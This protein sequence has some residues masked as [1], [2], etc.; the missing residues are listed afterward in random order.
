MDASRRELLD[1]LQ[2]G[3]VLLPA[4]LSAP[5]SLLGSLLFDPEGPLVA[6]KPIPHNP[7]VRTNKALVALVHGTDAATMLNAG[8]ELFG[9]LNRLDLGGKRVLLKPNVVNDRPPP[10]TTSVPVVEAVARAVKEAGAGEVFV[11]DSSGI[12]RFPT[13]ENLDA[14]GMRAAA[15]RAGAKV[16]ALEVHPWVRVEPPR[17]SS[18]RHYYLSR[19]VYEADVFINLPVIKTH[20]FADYSCSLKNL[21]GVTHPRYR[22]SVT[23]LSGE[24]HERIAELNLAVHP[25]LTIADGTMIMVAG[26]PTSGTA[27]RG[28]LLLL[29]GDRVA[30]DVV[31]LAILRSFKQWPKIEGGPVWG[32]RQVKRAIELGLGVGTPGEV[33]LVTATTSG[34]QEAFERLVEVIRQDVGLV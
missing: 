28:D 31:A 2:W 22:P 19:P 9:G 4:L 12:I 10:T 3:A 17:A 21:V 11:A 15:E 16:L 32:Q 26:G 8:L 34:R 25:H 14:T 5:K 7:F 30:L 27:A 24:W 23:F 6:P 33:E 29:S 13:K 1:R 18:L 20:R